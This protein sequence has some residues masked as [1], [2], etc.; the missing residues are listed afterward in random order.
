MA[1][2]LTDSI[3]EK[4]APGEMSIDRRRR[5]GWYLFDFSNSFLII[6]GGLY[7]PQWIVLEQGVSDFWFNLSVTLASIALLVTGPVSGYYADCRKNHIIFLYGL[8]AAMFASALLLGFIVHSQAAFI[9]PASLIC[10]GVIMYGYQLSLVHYN[11]MLRHMTGA[12]Q[13]MITSGLG[14][15]WGWIGGIVGIL[16]TYPLAT[17]YVTL[18][19]A[20]SHASIFI[21]SS[22]LYGA[23]TTAALLL[24][25]VPDRVRDAPAVPWEEKLTF[26]RLYLRTAQQLRFALANQRILTFLICYILFAEAILTVQNNSTIVLEVLFD[27]G[28]SEKAFLFIGFLVAAAI[29]APLVGWVARSITANRTLLL[30][31]IGWGVMLTLAALSS[32]KLIFAAIFLCLGILFGAIWNLSRVIYATSVPA[33]SQGAYFGVYACF[34]RITSIVGPMFWTLPLMAVDPPTAYRLALIVMVVFLA[35]SAIAA[36]RMSKLDRT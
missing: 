25:R 3:Q 27:Y 10:F 21:M 34:E 12:N 1:S 33:G 7:F 36:R 13:T 20:S 30:V 2:R 8:S 14:L 4:P 17:G 19:L 18:G 15:A 29:G 16:A 31:I 9:V 35:G 22:L 23:L 6:S 32:S 28:D 24:M 11:A 26:P 5:Y